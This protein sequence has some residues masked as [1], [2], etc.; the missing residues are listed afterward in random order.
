M[1]CSASA[2]KHAYAVRP[3]IEDGRSDGVDRYGEHIGV[4]QAGVGGAPAF[5]P[6]GALE[7]T[8]VGL[9]IECARTCRVDHQRPYAGAGMPSAHGT[10]PAPAS[11][12]PP[13]V[14]FPSPVRTAR[15][16][17]P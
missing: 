14:A 5:C 12:P 11:A 1:C 10:T 3:C 4:C 16:D 15:S 13:Y 7:K 6:I 2:V 8:A 9:P 17:A